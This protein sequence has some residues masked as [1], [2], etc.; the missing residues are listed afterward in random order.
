VIAR[1]LRVF[2]ERA[3][4]ENITGLAAMVAFNLALAVFPFALLMLFVFGQVLENSDIQS[5]V[6]ND[7]Q[8]LFP[9]AEQD[10]LN[11]ALERIQANSTTIGIVAAVGAIWIGASFWGAMDTAFCRI[12]HVECRGW[13]EQKRFALLML[14]VVIGFLAASVIIPVAEGVIASRADDLPFGLDEVG[15]VRAVAVLAVALGLTFAICSL[16]YYIV[17]KGHVPWRGVWAG[18]LFVTV[19]TAVANAVFPF[20][21][22]Q[23]SIDQLGGALGFILVAL[24]WF[25]LVALA[26]MA[27]AVINALRYELHDI[28]SVEE[29]R[30]RAFAAEFES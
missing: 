17:P 14:V 23:S 25:Y 12:Y 16:I 6:L 29:E 28:G 13:V 27:G 8:G 5:S 26:L 1:S 19:T 24:I 10:E 9:A 21:L 2:W 7:L 4:R 30:A 22:A 3:Y 11:R 18:A 20:Y 15:I